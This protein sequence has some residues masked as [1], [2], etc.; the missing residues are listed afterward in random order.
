MIELGDIL[1]LTTLN[2][3]IHQAR[4]VTV[5]GITQ[6]QKSLLASIADHTL[7]FQTTPY[8]VGEEIMVSFLPI[9]YVVD[10]L[11]RHFLVRIGKIEAKE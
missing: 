2:N 3:S 1:V 5:I 6:L 8:P 9:Y 7:Y 4:G 10:L 11:V